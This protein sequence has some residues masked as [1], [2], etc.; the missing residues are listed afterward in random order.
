MHTHFFSYQ[1]LPDRKNKTVVAIGDFD[2]VHFGHQQVISRAVQ[3]A[4]EHQLESAVM[5]FKPHPREVLGQSK[6]SRY[7]APFHKKIQ[8]I[9]QLGVDHTWIVHFD[10]QFARVEAKD[11]VHQMLV[12][13]NIHTVVVGFDFTFG[14]RGQGTADTLK[15]LCKDKIQV[16]VISPYNIDGEKVSSTLIREQLHIGRVDRIKTLTGRNYSITGTVIKGEQRGSKIGFPTANIELDAPYVIPSNGVYAVLLKWKGKTY[17]G[18]MNIGVKP[19]FH[20]Q[21]N[22]FPTIEVHLLDFKQNLYGQSVEI[23]FVRFLRKEKKFL[24]INELV[25]QIENDIEIA[26]TTAFSH[27]LEG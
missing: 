12:P 25:C 16:E 2:G 26:K 3:I 10:K 13:L 23:E 7:L 20:N 4:A 19:T 22:A 9:E 18:V 27:Q 15:K 24:S 6:Y 17:Q 8:L 11:F 21:P 1:N 14:H 5:T